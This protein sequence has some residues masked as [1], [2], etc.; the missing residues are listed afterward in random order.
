MFVNNISGVGGVRLSALTNNCKYK[1]ILKFA[2]LYKVL[3]QSNLKISKFKIWYNFYY[4][5][6]FILNQV[7][8]N[9]STGNPVA[10]LLSNWL[11]F[12][13]QD[14]EII[15]TTTIM[16]EK[17]KPVFKATL[18]EGWHNFS[19]PHS[20]EQGSQCSACVASVGGSHNLSQYYPIRAEFSSIQ[21][22]QFLFSKLSCHWSDN[23]LPGSATCAT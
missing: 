16:E 21:A 2:F 19:E 11:P 4:L 14:N 7:L 1:K 13:P 23:I 5:F 9:C 12:W 18:Y 8:T 3:Y 10:C 6:K 22:F 20:H 15:P 17:E